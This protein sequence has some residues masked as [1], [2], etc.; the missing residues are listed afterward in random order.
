MCQKVVYTY[1]QNRFVVSF[2]QQ[3]AKLPVLLR[4]GTYEQIR[5]GRHKNESSSLPYGSTVYLDDI[6]SGT[7]DKYFPKP[8]RLPISSFC[9][10]DIEDKA[11]WFHLPSDKWVQ[12]MLINDDEKLMVYIVALSPIKEV[13]YPYWPKVM[14]G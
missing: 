3:K 8:V 14:V 6:L 12:G 9:V 7:W 2:D 1:N 10:R 5:W 11:T 4:N 13:K